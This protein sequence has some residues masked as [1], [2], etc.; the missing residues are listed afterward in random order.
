MERRSSASASWSACDASAGS[1][2]GGGTAAAS[3]RKCRSIRAFNSPAVGMAARSKSR[4]TR[5]SGPSFARMSSRIELIFRGLRRR[6][7]KT[8]G[9]GQHELDRFCEKKL[10]DVGKIQN[11]QLEDR[12]LKDLGRS[13]ETRRN[14]P[15]QRRNASPP[16]AAAAM[17]SCGSSSSGRNPV[18]PASPAAAPK[19]AAAARSTA[20]SIRSCLRPRIRAH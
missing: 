7:L 8:V 14:T 6:C 17:L 9:I 20:A 1:I 13:A 11:G 12:N 10:P 2:A 3:P 4:T 19:T 15:T 18:N 16:E 5:E